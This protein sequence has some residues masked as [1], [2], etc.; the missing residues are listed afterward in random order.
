MYS[1][2]PDCMCPSASVSEFPKEYNLE[3]LAS[4]EKEIRSIDEVV[5]RFRSHLPDKYHIA[6][7]IKDNLIIL[8]NNIKLLHHLF[9]TKTFGPE[10]I[11]TIVVIL[12]QLL[13]V[14]RNTKIIMGQL[15][16]YH[17]NLANLLNAQAYINKQRATLLFLGISEKLRKDISDDEIRKIMLV[18]M[19]K[20]PDIEWLLKQD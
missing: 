6:I 9:A 20:V 18:L 7:M 13:Q 2:Y 8:M 14:I 19:K 10:D 15:S 12:N 17:D 11:S 4:I 16:P 5:E 1:Y 3:E